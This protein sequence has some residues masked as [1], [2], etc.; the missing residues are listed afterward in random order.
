MFTQTNPLTRLLR[1]TATERFELIITEGQPGNPVTDAA[2]IFRGWVTSVDLTGPWID[3]D[4]ASFGSLFSRKIPRILLQPT[5]NYAL[6]DAGNRLLK[7]DW[8][9]T[10]H[11]T[12]VVGN[13]FTLDAFTWP[14]GALPAIGANYF[15]LGYI[16]RPVTLERVPIISSTAISGGVL[17][18]TLSH[19]LAN[20]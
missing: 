19:A 5:D 4:S 20:G 18:V 7:A 2:A 11:L 8:T 14:G 1:R 3:A 12:S 10:A 15:A 13:V 16:E 17:T 6:F 9:F